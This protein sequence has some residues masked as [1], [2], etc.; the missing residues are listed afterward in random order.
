MTRHILYPQH[1]RRKDKPLPAKVSDSQ[2]WVSGRIQASGNHIKGLDPWACHFR[3]CR[4]Y[5]MA[6]GNVHETQAGD[7]AV[8]QLAC[9]ELLSLCLFIAKTMCYY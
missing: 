1:F 5:P 2:L 8:K 7:T 3:L 9:C 6:A 4:S